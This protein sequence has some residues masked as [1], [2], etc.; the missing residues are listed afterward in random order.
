[1]DNRFMNGL[2]NATN[3]TYT[4]NGALTHKSTNSMLL[5]MFALGGAYRVRS[6][7]DVILLFKNAYKE[8]PVYALK[9]LF[10]L[11]DARGGQGERRFF[12]VCM[13]WLANY[14]V[15][16]TRRNLRHVAEYGRW[17]DLYCFINTPLEAEAFGFIK[18][19]LVLDVQC[20][21]PSLLAKWLKSENTSSRTSR[22][23]ANKTREYLGWTHK[24]Y[25]K[26]LSVL[27][28]RINVLERLMSAGK[29]DEI[30]FDK[31][32]SRAGFIYKNAFARHDIERMKSDKEVKTYEE[33][34]KDSTTKVN[35]KVL[36]P[37]EC[38]A[39]AMKI[40]R[41]GWS[42]YGNTSKVALDDTQR[43]MTNKYWDNL[44]DYFNG[45]TFNG[46][47]IVDTSGSMCGI[48]A[49]APINV[50]ISL[51]MYC[52]EKAKGPFANH[53]ITFSSHPTFVKV[54]GVDFCD[55]VQRMARADWGGSTNVEAAFDLMLET[56]IRNKCS[57]DEIPQNLIIISDMEFNSC[58]TSNDYGNRYWGGT[59][60][61]ND[62]LFEKMEA[63]W[64]AHGYKMPQLT[65]WNVQ[66]RQNNI[67]MKT[68]GNVNFVSGM[69][70][71]IYEQIMKGKTAYDLMMD[72]LDS[73]RYEVIQ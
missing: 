7:E 60:R 69:S 22:Q 31:I 4:E 16:A 8:N 24:Q 73:K 33:F 65:F 46:M 44:A 45:A 11:R 57:Q 43:L 56:A 2:T 9:C 30:E 20:K 27:R 5:D 25:R 49:D 28:E 37:Y 48:N 59:V 63:K 35:A 34:A 61:P 19:Q 47:A 66:A 32:P 6:D 40:M 10:Y 42:W 1:M 29:W 18:E 26:T 14:D 3:I 17:D 72:K 15:E 41:N 51:G 71:V 36:Y 54:E 68:E 58:V 38:V 23:L 21:T 67:P 13:K 12:R 55:K 53:F 70:P 39:E 52:A 62:T 50:A 64:R